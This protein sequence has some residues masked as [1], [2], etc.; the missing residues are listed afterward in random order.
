MYAVPT[1]RGA[2]C[3]A[4]GPPVVTAQCVQRLRFGISLELVKRD[5]SCA[6]SFV[7]HGLAANDVA[8]VGIATADRVYEARARR[9]SFLI[10]LPAS[11]KPSQIR[12]VVI[13]YSDHP[14]RSVPLEL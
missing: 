14:R 10:D 9:N 6:G 1:A 12:A 4:I 7:A 2:A 3:Y 11:L 13:T 5:R 8:T